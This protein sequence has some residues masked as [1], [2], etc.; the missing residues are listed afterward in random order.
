MW[1]AIDFDPDFDPDFDSD[2]DSDGPTSGSAVLTRLTGV[3][4]IQ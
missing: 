3:A 4:R 2:F 1:L